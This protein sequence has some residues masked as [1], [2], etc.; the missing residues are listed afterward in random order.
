M[1]LPAVSCGDGAFG[2]DFATLVEEASVAPRMSLL[3]IWE[4]EMG[5]EDDFVVLP[6]IDVLKRGLTMKRGTLVAQPLWRLGVQIERSCGT[7]AVHKGKT[8]KSDGLSFQWTSDSAD[9]LK[10]FQIRRR[11]KQ[12]TV[13]AARA[14]TG[15]TVLGCLTDEGMVGSLNLMPTVFIFPDN[16]GIFGV[17][18]GS[19][20]SSTVLW[21]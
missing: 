7:K 1:R 12:Y 2:L 13:A 16:L 5:L 21:H 17:P 6:L 8:S 3:R 20:R 14:T 19:Q 18:P 15:R 10:P 4:R 11:L 9:G